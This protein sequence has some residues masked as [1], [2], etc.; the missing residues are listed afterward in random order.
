MKQLNKIAATEK[1]IV[2]KLI[3]FYFHHKSDVDQSQQIKF[4]LIYIRDRGFIIV[5][6]NGMKCSTKISINIPYLKHNGTP[7]HSGKSENRFHCTYVTI[8]KNELI[9]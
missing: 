2:K 6:K 4:K 5:R 8:F 7:R 3:K 1:R 9:G